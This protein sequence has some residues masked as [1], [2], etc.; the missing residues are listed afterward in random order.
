MKSR[1]NDVQ[2]R[3]LKAVEDGVRSGRPLS[4]REIGEAVGI[5]WPSHVYYH[6]HVLREKGYLAREEHIARSTRPGH[7][8]GVPVAGEIAAGYPLA[9]F[10]D[11]ETETLDVGKHLRPQP[12]QFALRVRGDSM[13]DDHI[14]DG[15]YILVRKG[16]DVH[17]GAIVVAVDLH[18][19][20]ERGAATVK[21]IYFERDHVRL[22]PANRDHEPRYIPLREWAGEDR[23]WEVHGTVTAVYRPLAEAS[24][25][26]W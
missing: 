24:A 20:G 10:P 26:R 6:L 23:K 1:L 16:A 4:I 8:P 18:G 19:D 3:I 25:S 22:Q 14:Y 12:E 2:V 15:D 9:L 21:R 7:E 11:G 13:I 17:D 5:H